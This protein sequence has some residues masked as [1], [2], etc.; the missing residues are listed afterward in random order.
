MSAGTCDR[1]DTQSEL[2]EVSLESIKCDDGSVCPSGSTCCKLSSGDWACCPLPHA[3][4][5]SDGVHC[6]PNGLLLSLS[7]IPNS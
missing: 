4:C 5:C 7:F 3:V 1:A 2:A 6:C